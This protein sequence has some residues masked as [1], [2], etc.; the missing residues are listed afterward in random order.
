[1]TY[2]VR[3]TVTDSPDDGI[4]PLSHSVVFTVNVTDEGG[5]GSDA[6]PVANLSVSPQAPRTGNVITLDAS[7]SVDDIG[8]V[9][10]HFFIEAPNDTEVVP[11]LTEVPGKV[12]FVAELAGEYLVGVF[13][14]DTSGQLS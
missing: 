2:T 14:E 13:V 7:G 11:D 12:T 4:E 10:W 9:A 1:G 5:G 6:P 8:I 3:L